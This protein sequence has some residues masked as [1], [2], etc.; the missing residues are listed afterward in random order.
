MVN[1]MHELVSDLVRQLAESD[2]ARRHAQAVSSELLEEKRTIERRLTNYWDIMTVAYD[3]A[4]LRAKEAEERARNAEAALADHLVA[5]NKKVESETIASVTTWANETF[6]QAKIPAMM[7]R[8]KKEWDELLDLFHPPDHTECCIP[9]K[10]AEEAA[11]VCICLYRVIGT[12]DPEAINKKMAKNR[13]RK[14][15]VDGQGCA[16]HVE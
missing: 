6:G 3:N 4:C 13:A 2:A 12:L 1:D 16:Q 15:Q 9:K 8:A 14:W 10:V 7:D 11:D 5:A